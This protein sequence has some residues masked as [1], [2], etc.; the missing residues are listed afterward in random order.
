[1]DTKS[2]SDVIRDIL[3]RPHASTHNA[4]GYALLSA[5]TDCLRAIEDSWAEAQLVIDEMIL[6]D[7]DLVVGP[8]CFL[9]IAARHGMSSEE[10]EAFIARHASGDS[11]FARLHELNKVRYLVDDFGADFGDWVLE[12]VAQGDVPIPCSRQIRP[13]PRHSLRIH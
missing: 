5:Q 10:S 4:Y 13:T 8:G 3:K 11:G 7:N 12:E 1:M 9:E 6:S 2:H